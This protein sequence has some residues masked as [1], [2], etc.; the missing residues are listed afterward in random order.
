MAKRP[1]LKIVDTSDLDDDDWAAVNRLFR[2]Y[3]AEGSDAFW[4][5]LRKLDDDDPVRYVK[6]ICAFF[7]TDMAEA[8]KDAL[9]EAGITPEEA[10]E[11][12]RKAQRKADSPASTKR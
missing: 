7:P 1:G 4:E 6:A 12:L 2:V 10:L 3:E 5:A 8:L 11:R 9:A